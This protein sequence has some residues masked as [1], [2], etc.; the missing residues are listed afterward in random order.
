[1]PCLCGD[2]H[3]YSCF[4]HHCLKCKKCGENC[5][6]ECSC[7]FS[8]QEIRILREEAEK[9]EKDYFGSRCPECLTELSPEKKCP[10]PD[11]ITHDYERERKL[12]EENGSHS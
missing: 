2:P 3:C 5:I 7:E 4:G 11:C 10:R 6:D 8:E 9:A 1:M 12:E